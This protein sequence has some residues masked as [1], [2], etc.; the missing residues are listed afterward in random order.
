MNFQKIGPRPSASHDTVEGTSWLEVKSYII[1][2]HLACSCDAYQKKM[3]E[4]CSRR[5]TQ[6][7]VEIMPHQDR[8]SARLIGK[9][10]SCRLLSQMQT[11]SSP[12]VRDVNILIGK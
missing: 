6:E 2:V 12:N 10:S 4:N 8:W 3:E 11:K 7:S 5:F 9:V 1:E